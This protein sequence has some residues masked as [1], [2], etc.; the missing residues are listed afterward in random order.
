MDFFHSPLSTL[1]PHFPSIYK[2]WMFGRYAALIIL[3]SFCIVYFVAKG[4]KLT[5]NGGCLRW[6]AIYFLENTLSEPL[7]SVFF[8]CIHFLL[9]LIHLGNIKM[10]KIHW[11]DIAR[12]NVK[13]LSDESFTCFFCEHILTAV[14]EGR[15]IAHKSIDRQVFFCNL[16]PG[17]LSIRRIFIFNFSFAFISKRKHV[18]KWKHFSDDLL[19]YFNKKKREFHEACLM[20]EIN[21]EYNSFWT[22]FN[23]RHA[24]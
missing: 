3:T 24:I 6:G 20:A 7:Y 12:E 18:N 21:W 2:Q 4:H 19:N 5:L 13:C 15:F 1:D 8:I 11:I 10:L 17:F 14:N 22:H 23:D 16:P 9:N